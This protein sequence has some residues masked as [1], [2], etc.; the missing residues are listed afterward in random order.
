MDFL[1]IFLI[2]YIG[3][4]LFYL[5]G[6]LICNSVE[7]SPNFYNY[8][9]ISIYGF[10]IL[11]LIILLTNFFFPINFYV[12][13]SIILFGILIGINFFFK[14]RIKIN[15]LNYFFFIS[16]I[17]LL[18]LSY[19]NINRPD[20]GL[21]HIPYIQTLHENK[22]IIGLANFHFRFGHISI[23]QYSSS[24]FN[25]SFFPKEALSVPVAIIISV[26]FIYLI[27]YFQNIKDNEDNK[28]IKIFIFFITLYS[29]YSF[30]RFSNFGNDATAHLFFFLFIIIYLK[31]NFKKITLDEFGSL[32]LIS[33]FA[34]LQKPFMLL[35]FVV[36]FF[37]YVIRIKILRFKIFFNKKII[38]SL[39]LLI[40]WTIK[41][42]MIS[43]CAIYPI[44]QTC[45]DNEL[46]INKDKVNEISIKSEA[47]AKD[48]PNYEK[49]KDV[50]QKQYLN[51]FIWFDVWKKN[52]LLKILEKLI[53]FISLCLLLTIIILI[54]F[55]KK[56]ENKSNKFLK[57]KTII[58]ISALFSFIWLIKFPLYRY[59]Q[60][61]LAILFISTL[62]LTLVK[63]INIKKVN[64]WF[65]NILIISFVLFSI[66][67]SIRI[68]QKKDIRNIY[69]NIYTLSELK[70]KN[71]K[72]KLQSISTINNFR[73]FYSKNECM[74][75]GSPCT[76][77][78]KNF[79]IKEIF[80]YK[81][82]TL[83]Y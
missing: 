32:F 26:F 51:F 34:Y 76:N 70:E 75:N 47:W 3:V 38:V 37:I 2:S 1:E 48:W 66:K 44:K 73:Y 22:I 78:K 42:F 33:T 20:A 72:E 12:C 40:F 41:N 58:L 43:G 10:I 25:N 17:S 27:S 56:R 74:Y 5:Y 19:S 18:L 30:N 24:I 6:S 68:Y 52:H 81:V 29:F 7:T 60:S 79:F 16:I 64:S 54:F 55:R 80:G 21:Y 8:S 39:F 14:K 49:K 23:I 4:F 9:L 13:N 57:T 77:L 69:P 83:L 71:T 82:I 45:L 53:P 35:L 11:S 61:F 15:L 31:I 46:Y 28:E 50:N 59:G 36:I 62:A 65:V 63:Y 67:N